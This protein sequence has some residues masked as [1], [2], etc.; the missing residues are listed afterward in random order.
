MSEFEAQVRD[1]LSTLDGTTESAVALLTGLTSEEIASFGGIGSSRVK[2]LHD[3]A[4][5]LRNYLTGNDVQKEVPW[6][7]AY[8]YAAIRHVERNVDLDIDPC[9]DHGH[10]HGMFG[11]Y[12]GPYMVMMQPSVAMALANLLDEIATFSERN[13]T[14]PGPGR[15]ILTLAQAILGIGVDN[16]H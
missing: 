6:C 9:D 14:A 10:D 3:A 13:P 2:I 12:A 7:P 11:R 15:T 5:K 1:A 8:A 16:G 4:N